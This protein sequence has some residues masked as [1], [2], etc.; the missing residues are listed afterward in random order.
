L[1]AKYHENFNA[2]YRTS[3]SYINKESILEVEQSVNDGADG[4]NGGMGDVLNYPIIVMCCGFHQPS[5]NLVNAFKTDANGLPMLDTY[6]EEDVTS[7]DKLEPTDPF[8]PY[9]G[10]LDPRLDWTVGRRDIPYLDWGIH[11]GRDWVRGDKVYNGP[12]S[13]KNNVVYKSHVGSYTDMSSWAPG[14]S[15]NNYKILRFADV[16]LYSAEAEIEL[17][18]LPRGLEL[19][20]LVRARA[21]NSEG[22]VMNEG[23]P[24]AN[25]VI[26]GYPSFADKQ[27][28]RK[29][30]RFER[31]LELGMEG[32]RFFDLVRWGVAAE[33]R[34]KYFLK[35][36]EKREYLS[37][38]NFVA[39]RNEVQ[40][41]PQRAIDLSY[42]D[43]KPTLV[44]NFDYN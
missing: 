28:A 43:G 7:D 35:E 33:E 4:E 44:Q 25:Y 21:A 29:A 23:T 10:N 24:A 18:N 26:K 31:R 9:S 19:I 12:Y 32:H 14:F 17:G 1:N 37:A 13:P 22:V 36:K 34:N 30:V 27:Y 8:T 39:G 20:N 41:I 40:P 16:M 38:G 2:E 15:A 42:K 11:G 6:N 5:Q 3:T